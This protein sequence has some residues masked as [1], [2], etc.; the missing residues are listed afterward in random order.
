LTLEL[1]NVRTGQNDK[2]SAQLSKGYNV[3]AG[4]KLTHLF[5]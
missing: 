2:E 5:D 4:A 1:V 3:S